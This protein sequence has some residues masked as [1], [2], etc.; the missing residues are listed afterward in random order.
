MRTAARETAVPAG[1]DPRRYARLL[2]RVWEATLA[3]A[4]R[5]TDPRPVIDESWR[6]LRLRGVDPDC[7]ADPHPVGVGE[8]ERRWGAILFPEDP[9]GIG[10]AQQMTFGIRRAQPVSPRSSRASALYSRRTRAT[11]A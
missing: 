9:L 4:P 6:R 7:G 3:G 10:C 11:A 2:A 1:A 5:P 8:L